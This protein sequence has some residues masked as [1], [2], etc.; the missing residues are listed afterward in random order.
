MTLYWRFMRA[1]C[2]GAD[3]ATVYRTTGGARLLY[4]TRSV[5]TK[6][7]ST[8]HTLLR[9]NQPPPSPWTLAGWSSADATEHH[10]K[11]VHS[12]H[13]PS[14]DVMM[15]SKGRVVGFKRLTGNAG[16]G[17]QVFD[18]APFNML[19]VRWNRG[20]TEGGSSGS[21]LFGGR[22]W[23][24]QYLIGVLT[25]GAS[26]CSARKAPDYYGRFDRTWSRSKKV[27]RLLGDE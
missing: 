25:G 16:G 5:A 11:L 9:L 26:S 24:N 2:R 10:G 19:E 17:L 14:G 13:H 4:T 22:R 1:Q 23:P 8:D 21:G 12:L 20:V 15:G 3:P 7:D 18:T 27:R 6:R